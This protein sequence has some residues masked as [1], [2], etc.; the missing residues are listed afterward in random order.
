MFYQLAQSKYPERGGQFFFKAV[1]TPRFHNSVALI[2]VLSK[3]KLVLVSVISPAHNKY[4]ERHMTWFRFVLCSSLLYRV[5]FDVS[6]DTLS[7]H[8][9]VLMHQS[10]QHKQ[11]HGKISDQSRDGFRTDLKKWLIFFYRSF[12]CHI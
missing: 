7:K 4:L 9:L 8:R 5:F 10:H 11:V 1:F 12:Q 2:M 6:S 3:H